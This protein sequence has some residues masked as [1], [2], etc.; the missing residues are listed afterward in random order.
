MSPVNS[1][2][3]NQE[4]QRWRQTDALVGMAEPKGCSCESGKHDLNMLFRVFVEIR[5]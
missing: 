3:T 1:G 5:K 4:L 2:F